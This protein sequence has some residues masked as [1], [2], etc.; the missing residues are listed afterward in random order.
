[1]LDSP[2]SL[3]IGN[4]PA[5]R[6]LLTASEFHRGQPSM[7]CMREDLQSRVRF[8]LQGLEPRVL[9]AADPVMGSAPDSSFP[10]GGASLLPTEEHQLDE[11]VGG[12]RADPLVY[13]PVNPVDA[14]FDQA[15][16]A[17][18]P[19][20]ADPTDRTDLTDPT[21][22][23]SEQAPAEPGSPSSSGSSH[24]VLPPENSPE[25]AGLPIQHSGLDPP[26]FSVPE[27]ADSGAFL[28]PPPVNLTKVAALRAGLTALYGAIGTTHSTSAFTSQ[29]FPLFVNT[30]FGSLIAS[31]GL[32]SGLQAD[33]FTP[34]DNWLRDTS[35][36]TDTALLTQ[37]NA[38]APIVPGSVNLNNVGTQISYDLHIKLTRSTNVSLRQVVDFPDAGVNNQTLDG[39]ATLNVVMDMTFTFGVDES[40]GSDPQAFYFTVG[41]LEY[42]AETNGVALVTM[43]GSSGTDPKGTLTLESALLVQFVPPVATAPY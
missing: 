23:A 14:L 6:V 4:N 25:P 17:A 13:Q 31:S 33:V 15:A 40:A 28:Q 18:A 11:P 43:T 20:A 9:L 21:N 32:H 35:G 42:R 3:R 2:D 34:L 8:D 37:I 27:L 1:M 19:L 16:L 12:V 24:S 36:P 30:S 39:T 38:L 29:R 5:S 26:W 22:R 7:R 41:R 10:G